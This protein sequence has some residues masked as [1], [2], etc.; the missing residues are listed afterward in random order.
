VIF[1]KRRAVPPV[2][3]PLRHDVQALI[4]TVCLTALFW[5]CGYA[6]GCD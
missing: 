4:F 6:C 1:P 2:S 3:W 5:P